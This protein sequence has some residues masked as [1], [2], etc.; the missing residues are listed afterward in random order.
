MG[1]HFIWN[2][3]LTKC[4]DKM[5]IY[6]NLPNCR[7]REE[8]IENEISWRNV[9]RKGIVVSRSPA[10]ETGSQNASPDMLHS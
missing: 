7:R 2:L 3:E 4:S 1:K 5:L 9:K 10:K 8:M 6:Q